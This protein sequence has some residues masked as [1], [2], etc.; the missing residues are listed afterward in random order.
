[1]ETRRRA[2]RTANCDH[3]QASLSVRTPGAESKGVGDCCTSLT[4][5]EFE[6][7][8]I[9]ILRFVQ[10][11]SFSKEFDALRRISGKD[12]GDQRG[13]AKRKKMVLKKESSLTRLDPFVQEGLLR[14]G[15][16]LSCADDLSEETK[17][18]VILP[19]KCHV[20]N[21]II[22]QLHERLAHV[23]RGHTLAKL[24]GSQVPMLLFVT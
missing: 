24:R 11:Q 7:A 1:M 5:Q 6:E 4:V 9:A 13:R 10:S 21:L 16:H 20:T 12:D 3:G 2:S 8:E 18:P 17:H 14:V 19:R 22:Q 23:G 15:G